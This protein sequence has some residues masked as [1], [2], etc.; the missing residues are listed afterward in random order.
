MERSLAQSK[1]A[2]WVLLPHESRLLRVAITDRHVGMKDGKL[3]DGG[4]FGASHGD[5]TNLRP[6]AVRS[7]DHGTGDESPVGEGGDDALAALVEGDVRKT[8]TV[9]GHKK[10]I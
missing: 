10:G 7:D 9:L 8:F 1:V 2:G 3:S 4:L 5:F 6:G